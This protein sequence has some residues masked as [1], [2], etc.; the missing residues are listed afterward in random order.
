[1]TDSK[2][3]ARFEEALSQPDSASSQDSITDLESLAEA[4]GIRL[5]E[6]PESFG[7]QA[8]KRFV[9]HRLAILGLFVFFGLV[10]FFYIGPYLRPYEFDEINVLD[11]AQGPGRDHW[12]GTD[13]I[14][15]DLFV[16]AMKGGQFSI[17][18]SV[19]TGL[20][21]AVIGGVLGSL[22]GYLGRLFDGAVNFLINS[23][24]TINALAVLL[25]LGIKFQMTPLVMAVLIAVLSWTRG[26]RIVRALVLQFKER[27][28]VLAA[29]AAGASTSRII[30]R[31]LLPNVAGALLVEATLLAG[32]AIILEST[33]SFLS[34]GV[35]PPETTLGTLIEEAKGSIDTSPARV[36][37]P[38]GLVTLIVLS[39]NFIGDGLRDALD[40]THEMDF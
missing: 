22:A 7:R 8:V 13:D 20:L 14:G 5:A 26:A 29:R 34:L 18:I 21:A 24:L 12:F 37:I 19:L 15:R 32:T 30:R 35:Q 6:K 11:R 4:E 9:G 1:M 25:I 33:L 3:A 2:T 23:L 38:G 17:R 40:P 10:V 16:R 39:I 36:L 28:F 31:H 27:E